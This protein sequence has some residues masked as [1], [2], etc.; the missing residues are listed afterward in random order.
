MHLFL[1]NFFLHAAGA[2]EPSTLPEEM[3]LH[4]YSEWNS[5]GFATEGGKVPDDTGRGKDESG[6]GGFGTLTWELTDTWSAAWMQAYSLD[7]P[8]NSA[9]NDLKI[10]D[11][12]LGVRYQPDT[13]LLTLKVDSYVQPAIWDPNTD[14][15]RLGKLA[16]RIFAS[17]PIKGSRFSFLFL[18]DA[19][20]GLYHRGVSSKDKILA[21]FALLGVSFE[22]T[23]C[24]SLDT[25]G[26]LNYYFK[27]QPNGLFSSRASNIQAGLVYTI[28]KSVDLGGFLTIPLKTLPSAQN[29]YLAAQ[30]NASIF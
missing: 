10:R 24:L 29:M 18:S 23:K 8:W 15:P 3:H 12:R 27:T 22:L 25:S 14:S 6:L 30:I 1:A 4:I 5:P 26:T 11:P 7:I 16:S 21:G 20:L 17:L 13:D 19:S 2:A 28:S 9:P